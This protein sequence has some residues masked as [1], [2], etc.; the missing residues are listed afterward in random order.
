M[1]LTPSSSGGFQSHSLGWKVSASLYSLLN[2]SDGFYRSELLIEDADGRI[3]ALCAGA[4]RCNDWDTVAD[5]ASVALEAARKRCKLPS[6]AK[7]HRRG[8]HHALAAGVSNGQGQKVCILLFRNKSIN[9]L[10]VSS[11]ILCH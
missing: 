8:T 11:S 5:A 2:S 10:T 7:K 6:K 4:P 3:I 9:T 1:D